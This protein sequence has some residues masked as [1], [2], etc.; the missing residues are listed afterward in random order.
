M[1][2]AWT[3]LEYE[4]QSSDQNFTKINL[5]AKSTNFARKLFGQFVPWLDYLSLHEIEQKIYEELRSALLS[6][7]NLD[8][9]VLSKSLT[10]IIK[11]FAPNQ[12][13]SSVN[14]GNEP[15]EILD[16]INNL[17]LQINNHPL[18]IGS[19]LTREIY[20]ELQELLETVDIESE[21]L[22][23]VVV[24]S[25]SVYRDIFTT[26]AEAQERSYYQIKSYLETINS[27]F[28]DK[29]IELNI[30]RDL[31]APIISIRFENEEV[32][33]SFYSLSSGEQQIVTLIYAAHMSQREVILIDEPEISLHVDWQRILLKKMSVQHQDKQIIVCTHSPII[34]AE[35]EE[36]L[37][38][39]GISPTDKDLWEDE[40][41]SIDQI[42]DSMIDFDTDDKDEPKNE[43]EQDIYDDS[44]EFNIVDQEIIDYDQ[45]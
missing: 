34:A 4:T 24:S 20:L 26:L 12:S 25:L 45:I 17:S 28:D 22:K 7:A 15:R 11:A 16:E 14:V 41:F 44:N 10:G 37:I 43:L 3:L 38:E 21:G 5:A 40:G 32:L 1:L 33:N 6:I 19:L 31:N 8:R 27:F 29:K 39:L 18:Q 9:E 23:N 42:T 30:T 13:V 36:R 35:Y 2:D